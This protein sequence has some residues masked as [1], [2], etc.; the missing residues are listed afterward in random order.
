[1]SS[2]EVDAAPAR[3]TAAHAGPWRV[4]MIASLAQFGISVVDQG[5]PTLAAFVKADLGLSAATVG[6]VV[7]AFP[8]GKIFGSYAAGRAADRFGERRVILLGGGATASFIALAAS[9][10]LAGVVIL[11]AF[12]GFAGSAA[13]PAGGRLV[14]NAFLRNRR[15]F[16]L[17]LRQ[18]AVPV[19][20]IFA[21][22]AL[23]WI[24]HFAGWRPAFVAAGAVAVVALVP[25]GR[26]RIRPSVARVAAAPVP[27]ADTARRNV[28]LLTIWGCLLVPGQYATLT[29]LALDLHQR[30]GF[31]LTTGSLLLVVA[32]AAG[33]VGRVG[34]GAVSDRALGSGRKPLLLVLNGAGLLGALLLFVMP[35][36]ASFLA[37]AGVAAVA[38][39][40]LIGFQGLWVTMVAEA[41]GPERVGA[42]TGFAITFA[43]MAIAASAPGFGLVADLAGSYR[44]IWLALAVVIGV[45]FLPAL[46]IREETQAQPRRAEQRPAAD[47]CR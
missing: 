22:A 1:M 27:M 13:T 26:L 33:A 32:N 31:A 9:A 3:Q 11:L 16:A 43:T 5:I 40:S 21:A 44:A 25:L 37:F 39:L 45:A 19:A 34:W 14:L 15:G 38:G 6:L 18:T 47:T 30:A 17:G 29:F 23:P 7:A 41:A 2:A 36:S 24:A 42:A 35:G 20:G 10:P 12:A 28:A 4:L 46:L 8:L